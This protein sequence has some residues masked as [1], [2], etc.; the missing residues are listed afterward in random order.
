M[1]T[2]LYPSRLCQNQMGLNNFSKPI[3]NYDKDSNS[4]LHIAPERSYS[5][6]KKGGKGI[7]QTNAHQ[8][9]SELE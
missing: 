7:K 8:D 3:S 6:K 9:E 4:L 2:K 5:E 1:R